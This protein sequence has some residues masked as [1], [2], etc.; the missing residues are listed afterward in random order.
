MGPKDSV[1]D[2]PGA[3]I[4]KI[5][6]ISFVGLLVGAAVLF[7][8]VGGPW[9]VLASPVLAIFGWFYI[10]PILVCVGLLWAFYQ[11]KWRRSFAA[12]LFVATG[13]AGASLLMVVIGVRGP[14]PF[15]LIAYIVGGLVAGAVCG[16][17]VVFLKRE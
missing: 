14:E 8:V 9:A 15:W 1:G 6:L 10:F 7:G 11:P 13:S 4:L 3:A 5:A 12:W 2:G 16:T 17:L